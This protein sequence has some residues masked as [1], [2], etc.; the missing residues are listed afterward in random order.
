[1]AITSDGQPWWAPMV[2]HESAFGV[3]SA[4]TLYGPESWRL[5]Q[6]VLVLCPVARG[7]IHS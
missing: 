7:M 4:K 2:W 6:E 5:N 1:M 3:G